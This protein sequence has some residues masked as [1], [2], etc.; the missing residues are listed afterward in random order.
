MFFDYSWESF[1]IFV[2]I[3]D[4]CYNYWMNTSKNIPSISFWDHQAEKGSWLTHQNKEFPWIAHKNEWEI[5]INQIPKNIS[6]KI[7]KIASK[8]AMIISWSLNYKT[9]V[10]MI[11][12]IINTSKS[13]WENILDT[14]PNVLDLEEFRTKNNHNHDSVFGHYLDNVIPFRSWLV[15]D[16]IIESF[17]T[18]TEQ[19]PKMLNCS[20]INLQW[21]LEWAW[22]WNIPPTVTRFTEKILSPKWFAKE[23]NKNAPQDYTMHIENPW[24]HEVLQIIQQQLKNG[25][26]VPMIY[27]PIGW[28]VRAP[29]FATIVGIG[30]FKEGIPMY[31]IQDSMRDIIPKNWLTE[32]ELLECLNF[33]TLRSEKSVENIALR[34]IA[35]SSHWYLWWNTIYI[36]QKTPVQISANGK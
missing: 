18:L 25:I 11:S 26:P 31:R 9:D 36:I 2:K 19:L 10:N 30:K 28:N 5:D 27:V 20:G 32:K 17:P 21:N 15:F 4:L 24:N 23:F 22:K 3:I 6:E 1:L 16:T 7:A 12:N 34:T 8:I 13:K 29:H 14:I 35:S 33:Q